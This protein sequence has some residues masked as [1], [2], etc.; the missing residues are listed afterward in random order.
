MGCKPQLLVNGKGKI[1]PESLQAVSNSK[2]GLSGIG[3]YSCPEKEVVYR[4]HFDACLVDRFMVKLLFCFDTQENHF[5]KLYANSNPDNGRNRFFV[6]GGYLGS[7][8]IKNV[9]TDI[10]EIQWFSHNPAFNSN[11]SMTTIIFCKKGIQVIQL[12]T[13]C[14]IF[15][16][17]P[18]EGEPDFRF[19]VF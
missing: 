5:K 16:K 13:C 8:W 11:I 15:T 17:D 7:C 3:G 2:G 12:N 1:G 6:I 10:Q 19:V 14:N 18:P 9:C 4:F